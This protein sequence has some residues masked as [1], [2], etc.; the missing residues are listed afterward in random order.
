[1]GDA[2]VRMNLAL[3]EEFDSYLE[4]WER[5]EKKMEE[6]R[7][8]RRRRHDA[9]VHRRASALA[10][11]RREE[12]AWELERK[13][14]SSRQRTPE[15]VRERIALVFEGRRQGKH[16]ALRQIKP[17]LWLLAP[18]SHFYL[19]QNAEDNDVLTFRQHK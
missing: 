17:E 9:Y 6:R 7:V 14:F 1:M 13:L 16:P 4:L 3:Q 15:W 8:A 19:S 5:E 2:L 12:H 10:R 11:A 18:T